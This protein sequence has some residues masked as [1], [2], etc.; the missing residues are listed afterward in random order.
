[1]HAWFSSAPTPAA[2]GYSVK[3]L[4]LS[5]PSVIRQLFLSKIVRARVHCNFHLSYDI[6]IRCTCARANRSPATI[7]LIA[8]HHPSLSPNSLVRR[9]ITQLLDSTA[10]QVY[11]VRLSRAI[12][13]GRGNWMNKAC[14]LVHHIQLRVSISHQYDGLSRCPVNHHA[15]YVVRK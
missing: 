12:A 14:V 9:F 8:A 11:S 7:T 15:C 4:H 3:D 6:G 2:F 5:Q 10:S 1:M 13:S